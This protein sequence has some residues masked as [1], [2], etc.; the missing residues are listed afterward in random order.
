[1]KSYNVPHNSP[2]RRTPGCSW[3][4]DHEEPA[5]EL[6]LVL[7]LMSTG[8]VGISD[9]IGHTNATMAKRAI[10]SDG[11]L[12]KPMKAITA[13]DASF[14]KEPGS[15]YL[16]STFG[17]GSSWIIVSFLSE[18]TMTI[19][20]RDFWPILDGGADLVYR[21]FHSSGN[22]I[23]NA[24]AVDSSCIAGVV[25]KTQYGTTDFNIPMAPP[26]H[27]SPYAPKITLFWQN[28]IESKWFLL[29]ELDK[30]VPL[31]PA[32]FKNFACT[33]SGVSTI[34][35]GAP[36]E[37]VELTA[38]EPTTDGNYKAVVINF[39]VPQ[40]GEILVDFETSSTV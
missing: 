30:Y 37:T 17:L 29:G 8:P 3:T 16:Y 4:L 18:D 27:A 5:A 6:H 22:C 36:G 24:D 19:S 12:L 14:L 13:V 26:H 2:F 35:M 9:A 1:M 10:R 20:K 7:A 32:R 39:V 31:S 21:H 33:A 34:V 11:V 28:C 15:N 40:K 38:L 23:H 25:S